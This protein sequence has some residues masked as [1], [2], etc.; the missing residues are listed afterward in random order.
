MKRTNRN[1]LKKAVLNS[2]LPVLLALIIGAI[3]IA[4]IGED[5]LATYTLLLRNLY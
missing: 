5:P 2:V 3:I 4:C 1:N